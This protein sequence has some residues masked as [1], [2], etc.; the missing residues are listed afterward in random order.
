MMKLVLCFELMYEADNDNITLCASCIHVQQLAQ[1][2][3]P[4]DKKGMERLAIYPSNE[5]S[6]VNSES[7]T[8]L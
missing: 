1:S 3:A 8:W 7:N 4:F 6:Q 2:S 5:P